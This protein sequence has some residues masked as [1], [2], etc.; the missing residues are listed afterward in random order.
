MLQ[1]RHKWVFNTASLKVLNTMIT[2]M[3]EPTLKFIESDLEKALDANLTNRHGSYR[4]SVRGMH[5]VQTFLKI[6]TALLN[7]YMLR[8]AS[9]TSEA[10]LNAGMSFGESGI[11]ESLTSTSG[12]QRSQSS[13]AS[14][15]LQDED[16]IAH[17]SLVKCIFVYSFV[18]G[19]GG[20]LSDSSRVKFDQYTKE[21]LYR[22]SVSMTL[23][24]TGSVYDLFVDVKEKVLA[25][26]QDKPA[27]RLRNIPAN[28]VITSDIE[29]IF[30]VTEML[31][32]A[33]NHVLITGVPG[34]GKTA[35][36]TNMLMT[37][38]HYTKIAMCPGL[39]SAQFQHIIITRLQDLRQKTVFALGPQGGGV[40]PPQRHMFF[41]DDLST[42][43][44]GPAD[45]AMQPCLEALRE[46]TA[47][48][49]TYD[50][51]RFVFEDT[52]PATF[53]M[54]CASPG[55]AGSGFGVN[56]HSLSDRLIRQMAV[57]NFFSPTDDGMHT[58]YGKSLQ[59]WLEEFPSYAAMMQGMLDLYKLMR[60]KFRA[61]PAQSHYVFTLHD[62]GRIVE[63]MLLL[64]PRKTKSKPRRARAKKENAGAVSNVQSLFGGMLPGGKVSKEKF[65]SL[66]VKDS[67]DTRNQSADAALPM[68]PVLVRLWCHEVSRTFADRLL[69]DDDDLWFRRTLRDLVE[70]HFCTASPDW[71]D[72]HAASR[73]MR[74]VME[75]KKLYEKSNKDAMKG[76]PLPFGHT[77]GDDTDSDDSD[78]SDGSMTEVTTDVVT[79][80]SE[81]DM[82][83]DS[84]LH[85][86]GGKAVCDKSSRALED[87]DSEDA[88]QG[89]IT[90]FTE[91][92]INLADGLMSPEQDDVKPTFDDYRAERQYRSLYEKSELQGRDNSSSDESDHAEIGS[93]AIRVSESMPAPHPLQAGEE[94]STIGVSVSG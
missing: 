33:H 59:T 93:Q 4:N 25:K 27:E 65:K 21:A 40:R 44:R 82:D 26:W 56:A 8:D 73:H 24:R 46:V 14:K 3:F 37:R 42:A 19:F 66:S 5:E 12:D 29:R 67:K 48:K 39:T 91:T 87:N 89:A 36:V 15:S 83:P 75:D 78:L 51:K 54:A 71:I 18:W 79:P 58:L 6:I 60:S 63:G 50:R 64:S 55:H 53:I 92:T 47:H 2:E 61:T 20:H 88:Y 38:Q 72:S 9:N 76:T 52:K 41:I 17:E 90:P 13:S 34:V 57:I 32:A 1:A 84:F 62:I 74:A 35:L 11:S 45:S 86:H 23:P 31:I 70:K 28:Y 81:R 22:C 43:A 30:H 68:M 80:F 94:A 16:Y 49:I 7:K 85:T 77:L 10:S 69:S